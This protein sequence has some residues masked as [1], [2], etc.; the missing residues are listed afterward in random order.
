MT[1]TALRVKKYFGKFT[2]DPEFKNFRIDYTSKK[3]LY[4]GD[5]FRLA[6]S[7]IP[8]RYLDIGKI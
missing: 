4:L 3:I 7:V 6:A 1:Q 5:N 8:P 2:T